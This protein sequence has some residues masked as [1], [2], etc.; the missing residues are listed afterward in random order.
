MTLLH[1]KL[2]ALSIL[3]IP[4]LLPAHA[5]VA[6]ASASGTP[7]IPLIVKD[8]PILDGVIQP[9]EWQGSLVLAAV[10]SNAATDPKKSAQT[11][12]YVRHD[13]KALWVAM[14]SVGLPGR[15][16]RAQARGS[17]GMLS[18][19]DA[20]TVALGLDGTANREI[21][22]GGYAGAMTGKL[23][24]MA[25]MYEFTV[26]AVGSTARRYNES[27]LPT[28]RFTAKTKR[29]GNILSGEIWEAEMRI[30][31]E[32]LGLTDATGREI[33]ANFVHYRSPGT[34]TWRGPNFWGNYTPFPTERI[35]LAASVDEVASQLELPPVA[36]TTTLPDSPQKAV[37]PALELKYLPLSNLMFGEA[38]LPAGGGAILDSAGKTTRAAAKTP[39]AD[40]RL[41]IPIDIPTARVSI[42]LPQRP[43]PGETVK[44]Q[45]QTRKRDGKP[46]PSQ[47]GTFQG[48]AKPDWVG[49]DVG[50]KFVNSAVP[51]PWTMPKIEGDT[52]R[53]A[54]VTLAFGGNALPKSIRGIEPELLARPIDVLTWSK[55]QRVAIKWQ[56]RPTLTAKG[57]HVIVHGKGTVNGSLIE[58]RTEVDFDGFMTT[59]VHFG[60]T[61][62]GIDKVQLSCPL[63]TAF[64]RFATQGSAQSI[65][66]ID[67]NDFFTNGG[68]YVDRCWVGAENIGLAFSTDTPFFHAV[69]NRDEIAVRNTGTSRDFVITPIDRAA[70][71]SQNRV[72]QFYLQPTPSRPRSHVTSDDYW[73]WFEEWSDFQGYPDLKKMDKVKEFSEKTREA[74]KV[75][76]L[77]FNQMLAENT[78]EFVEYRDEIINLPPKMW[79]KRAYD[80]PGKGVP[81]YVCCVR[82]PYG[83]LLLD[84]IRKLIDQGDIG[85][86]YMDGTQVAWYCD[87]PAHPA[88][89]EARAPV[90]NK[91]APSRITGTR[92]FLKR[93]RGLFAERGKKFIMAG[94][95]G[96]D[97]D[98][99]TLSFVD[100]FWEGEQLARF[101][102]GYR[103]PQYQFAVGY[104]GG[105]W[106]YRT[107]FFDF[108][109]TGNRGENWSLTYSLLFNTDNQRDNPR[110]F[111]RPFEVSG[112]TF[113]PYWK[114]GQKLLSS[115]KTKRTSVSF[116]T[117]PQS[118]AMIV[119]SNFDFTTDDIAIDVTSLTTKA[120]APNETIWVD[121]LTKK[122]YTVTRGLLRLTLPGYQGVVLRPL[123][124]VSKTDQTAGNV[125]APET[126]P[127]VEI[128]GMKLDQWQTTDDTFVKR[129]EATAGNAD[130]GA[131]LKLQS[132]PQVRTLA[133]LPNMEFGSDI[134]FTL[135]MKA[136]NR[137]N[138]DLGSVVVLHDTDWKIDAAPTGWNTGSINQL[139]L[140]PDRV[141]TLHVALHGDLLTVQMDGQKVIDEMQLVLRPQAR[142]Q[143]K[144]ST[145]AGDSLDLQLIDLTTRT[146]AA[147]KRIPTH[148]ALL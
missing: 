25:H 122:Q 32:A 44:A 99:N 145:W 29:S 117:A 114:D 77:Y 97:L 56:A 69:D 72:L 10:S 110:R 92:D 70:Q 1:F 42:N 127:A 68:Q 101:L 22:M 8:V 90:W 113:H 63:Q 31:F 5:S 71:I 2:A 43:A 136:S 49:T 61:P 14:R 118:A 142:G 103:I 28:P 21:S 126:V 130:T 138:I 143:L 13:G 91:P 84:G 24:T 35:R 9:S 53:L 74:G 75:P 125:I 147:T 50:L 132:A 67:G 3:T 6:E 81:C 73:L 45:L 46:G 64:A 115:S 120:A 134:E 108:G 38:K 89:D 17:E 36:T 52:V 135:K 85:G 39:S 116:Y 95:T 111:L 123:S 47:D 59:Q 60:V 48:I 12:F 107:Q 133:T 94:H 112:A 106:G 40:A 121:L 27:P 124:Q 65:I 30:P 137:L 54:H 88:C 104:S 76:L 105:P 83:D 18:L 37:E 86:V 129:E 79:Y 139:P 55:G 11:I 66:P 57:S 4:L 82:G 128:K 131:W 78:P 34:V 19:D 93:L 58:V 87:N 148:P 15:A 96:G 109:W 119:A 23:G 20:V 62:P 7:T 80:N 51:S 100:Y 33:Y 26:N 144:I 146:V 98:I 41:S 16:I 141:V 102:P 140:P